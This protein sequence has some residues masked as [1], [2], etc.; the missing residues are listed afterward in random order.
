MKILGVYYGHTSTAALLVDGVITDCVSEE[1][2]TNVKNQS[3]LPKNSITY[4]LQKHKL[5]GLDLDAVVVP[6]RSTAPI[7]ASEENKKSLFIQLVNFI[8]YRIPLVKNTY[9]FVSFYNP[10]LR[11][12]GRL[13]Y[14]L[15]SRTVGVYTSSKERKLLAD[16]LN[17]PSDKLVAHDHHK[18]H[19][20]AGY[21]ASKFSK[22]KALVLTLDAEGDGVCATVNVF[23]KGR[24]E[25]IS[26]T[27]A[28]NSLGLMYAAVT[29]HLGMKVGE[30]EYKVMGLAPYAKEYSINK[31][32]IKVQD[33]FRLGG[34]DNL[35][36]HSKFDMRQM[37][38]YLREEMSEVRFD[39]LAGVFQKVLEDT[40]L[41]WVRQAIKVTGVD[42]LC[43]TGGVFMNV[44]LNQKITEL[45]EVGK[46]FF[47]PSGS[48][49]SS[50]LGA[51]F[52]SY[53]ESLKSTYRDPEIEP[54]KDLYLGPSYSLQAVKDFL[55]ENSVADKYKV[56]YFE[57]IE[58]RIA[59]LL[60]EK[61][62]VGRLS[63]RMEWGA[64]ALGNRTILA[65]PSDPEVVMIIN[66][67][68]KDRDFWMPF[69]PSILKERAGDYLVNPKNVEA[70]Y[71]VLSFATTPLGR[72]DLKAALHPYDFTCRPQIVEESW[73]PKYYKI[74]K[75]FENLTGIGGVLNTSF[76]LHG[77]PIVL[78]P[79]EAYNAFEKSGLQYLALENYLISKL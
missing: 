77:Y 42:T 36:I 20:F 5:T 66:E 75:E 14:Q 74:I 62:I 35:E 68:M 55:D 49:E 9:G 21:Y 27:H 69:A 1:R 43:C 72:G 4:I 51:C 50:P 40:V 23:N 7:Y 38:K 79:K 76:N 46:V 22:E 26:R 34:K 61:K 29:K 59:L 18:S 70:P 13:F 57:D 48:D 16:Y 3:G 64:R 30:H 65:N 56:E 31:A 60:S 33:L 58:K 15:F 53:V 6:V 41:A 12:L 54:I 39:V 25:R 19:A 44:K 8:Y 52:V 17:I 45:P 28:D 67:Q 78:G 2:F 10:R 63:G 47:M 37:P 11:N 73:N 24:Y 71:M 32:F